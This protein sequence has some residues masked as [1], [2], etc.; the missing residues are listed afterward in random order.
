MASLGRKRPQPSRRPVC[1]SLSSQTS[2]VDRPSRTPGSTGHHLATPRRTSRR[3]TAAR[4]GASRRSRPT[5]TVH[6]QLSAQ[7]PSTPNTGPTVAPR[8]VPFGERFVEPSHLTKGATL[9]TSPPILYRL[10][11]ASGFSQFTLFLPDVVTGPSSRKVLAS[12]QTHSC[13]G[14]SDERQT[15]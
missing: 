12:N 2:F 10:C 13:Y 14:Q 1:R 3:G 11:A 5:N 15:H 9:D 7:N 8:S 6:E 4:H